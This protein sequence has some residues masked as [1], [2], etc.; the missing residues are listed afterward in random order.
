[1][2]VFIA[3]DHAVVREGIRS[4]IEHTPPLEWAGSASTAEGLLATFDTLVTDVLLLDLS[5][6]GKSCTELLPVLHVR[7]ESL[8]IVVYSMYP[9]EQY[10][11]WAV[12]NGACAY[13]SKSRPLGALLDAILLRAV[14][15]ATPVRPPHHELTEKETLVFLAVA[16]S[17]TPS[18]IA[19]ELNIAPSTVST[20]LKAIRSKLGLRS[21]IEIAQYAA[22]H[23]VT[24]HQP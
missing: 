18:E 2:K 7:R 8:K 24:E 4:W 19:W 17:K 21:L 11:P 6:P 10:E 9:A 14:N 20:H 13:V 15:G 16:R 23:R 22:R 5:L 12:A 1:M 3:D